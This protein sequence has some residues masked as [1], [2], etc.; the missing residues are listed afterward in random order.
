[1]KK[2]NK[3]IAVRHE[4]APHKGR[5]SHARDGE[6]LIIDRFFNEKPRGFYVDVGAH[7]P[8]RFS[9]T[10]FFYK[11]GWRGINIDPRPGIMEVLAVE[12]PSDINVAEAIGEEG[13]TQTL[14]IFNDA[15]H[16]TFSQEEA[17]KNN[18]PNGPYRIV[19]K[20]IFKARPLASVL[21]E[22][23]PVAVTIDFLCI[24]AEGMGFKVLR[25]NNWQKYTPSLVIIEPLQRSLE[26]VLAGDDHCFLKDI[27]YQLCAKSVDWIMYKK[28]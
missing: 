21:D 19:D 6:D 5:V 11:K 8:S 3:I 16:S 18:G 26:N 20:R 23:M 13:E 27:G 24:D 9:N 2:L 10:F 15:A 7:H 14:Y 17:E 22:C 12:R 1:V 25:T 4:P 28:T